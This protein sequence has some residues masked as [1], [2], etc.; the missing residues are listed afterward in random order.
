M[1]SRLPDEAPVLTNVKDNVLVSMSLFVYC[2]GGLYNTSAV[3][4]PRSSPASRGPWV[5]MRVVIHLAW[6][7][8]PEL[9]K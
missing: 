1:M 8:S 7:M 4:V 6:K 3:I 5:T 9:L 2:F